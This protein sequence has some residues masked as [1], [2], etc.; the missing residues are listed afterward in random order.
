MKRC[1]KCNIEKPV[2]EFYKLKDGRMFSK[3]KLCCFKYNKK[4]LQKPEVKDKIV[5]YQAKYFQN[6]IKEYRKTPKGKQKRTDYRNNASDKTKAK[7]IKYQIKY[8]QRPDI[9]KRSKKYRIEYCQRPEVKK[10]QT[11]YKQRPYVKEKARKY[12]QRPE[13]KE[14]RKKWLKQ[15]HQKPYVQARIKKYHIEY[16]KKNK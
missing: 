15:Y 14:K 4:R 10:R 1:L 13:V 3:C 16:Y 11:Q 12:N 7:R 5:W 6:K 8:N 9:Q 2:S